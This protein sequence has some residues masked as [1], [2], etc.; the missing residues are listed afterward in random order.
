[1]THIVMPGG[2]IITPDSLFVRHRF[3]RNNL[4]VEMPTQRVEG[5]YKMTVRRA[6]G[7]VKQ[8]TP[9]FKN[10]ILNGGMD[11]W[12]GHGGIV[13][14]FTSIY[15]GTSNTPP[16]ATQTGLLAQVAKA[17]ALSVPSTSFQT[18]VASPWWVGFTVGNRFNAGQLNGEALA[19]IGIGWGAST[20]FSRALITPDGTNPGTITVLSD[21]TLECFYQVRIYPATTDATGSITLAGQNYGFTLRPALLGTGSTAGYNFVT[22]AFGAAQVSSA[23]FGEGVGYQQQAYRVGTLGAITENCTGTEFVGSGNIGYSASAYTN[24]AFSRTHSITGGLTEWNT[25]DG[26]LEVF[27]TNL[28]GVGIYQMRFGTPIPKG[29]TKTLRLDFTS[30]IA[31]RP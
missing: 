7:S 10:L 28:R 29:P 12:L 31:R 9:W 23:S 19:E 20:L 4:D 21:E 15:V 5:L 27:Q 26:N 14:A 30:S 25:S 24:G 18:S 8:E 16:T 6:D 13:E 11:R 3:A 22:A 17:G 1:M 2:Q